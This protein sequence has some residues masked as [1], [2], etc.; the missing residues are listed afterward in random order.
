MYLLFV[1]DGFSESGAGAQ[2]EQE[3]SL[4][5]IGKYECFMS[6]KEILEHYTDN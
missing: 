6:L 4:N 2:S 1:G 3:A 5:S